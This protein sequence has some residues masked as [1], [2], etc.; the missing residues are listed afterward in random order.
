MTGVGLRGRDVDVT[1]EGTTQRTTNVVSKVTECGVGW[2]LHGHDKNLG[3]V[4]ISRAV[5]D[6]LCI[7]T[8]MIYE[9][10]S[11]KNKTK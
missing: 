8:Q 3:F 4:T 6:C 11:Q 5:I 2:G 7:L 9:H 1:R 10:F